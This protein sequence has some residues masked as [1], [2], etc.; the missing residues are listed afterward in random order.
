MLRHRFVYRDQ[1]A[2]FSWV[3][4]CRD[5]GPGPCRRIARRHEEDR[6]RALITSPDID[7]ARSLFSRRGTITKGCPLVEAISRRWA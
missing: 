7:I 5:K 4:L 6:D 2:H 3:G 1:V